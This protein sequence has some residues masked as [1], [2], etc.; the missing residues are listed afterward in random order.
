MELLLILLLMLL[1]ILVISKSLS[2][3]FAF[4]SYNRRLLG[5]SSPHPVHVT[6]GIRTTQTLRLRGAAVELE[7]ELE[8]EDGVGA[9]LLVEPGPAVQTAPAVTSSNTREHLTLTH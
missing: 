8:L 2:I 1:L 4:C 7:P 3:P 9:S 5:F 6:Q